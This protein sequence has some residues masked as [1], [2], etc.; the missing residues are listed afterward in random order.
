MQM[1]WIAISLGV[2]VRQRVEEREVL[3]VLLGSNDTFKGESGMI[4]Q[5]CSQIGLLIE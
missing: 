5:D 3:E 4:T 1:I 2:R